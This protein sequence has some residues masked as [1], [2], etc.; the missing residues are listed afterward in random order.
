MTVIKENQE[1]QFWTASSFCHGHFAKPMTC[2]RPE[3][4]PSPS[5]IRGCFWPSPCPS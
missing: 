5:A 1:S 2:P 4:R 3:N